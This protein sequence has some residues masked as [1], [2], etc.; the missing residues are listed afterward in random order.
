M[1]LLVESSERGNDRFEGIHVWVQGVGVNMVQ[2]VSTAGVP[3][4][5]GEVYGNSEV[6]L[7]TKMCLHCPLCN[8][9]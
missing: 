5:C 9:Q 3:V 7:E 2:R 8:C 6:K 4:V 1:S